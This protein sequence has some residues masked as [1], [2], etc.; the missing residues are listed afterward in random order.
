MKFAAKPGRHA[1][2]I[3]C[4]AVALLGSTFEVY[5]NEYQDRFRRASVETAI[6]RAQLGE[7]RSVQDSAETTGGTST[8]VR[9]IV[10]QVREHLLLLAKL[11]SGSNRVRELET[12][13]NS[14]LA[15]FEQVQQ[16]STL[17]RSMAELTATQ[18]EAADRFK[19]VRQALAAL[20]DVYAQ[21]G[22]RATTAN[23]VG[24]VL[25]L[26]LVVLAVW[27]LAH[28]LALAETTG[29]ANEYQALHDPL[30]GLPNRAYLSQHLSQVLSD[31]PAAVMLVDLDGFKAVNDLLGHEAGD[32]LLVEMGGR[33]RAAVPAHQFIARLGG[34]EFVVVLSGAVT[35]A[36][37]TDLADRMVAAANQS[38]RLAGREVFISA[39]I[40][41]TRAG[42]AQGG[43]LQALR[44][45][46]AAMYEAKRRGK[47]QWCD[48][49]L[50]MDLS[51]GEQLGL[52]HELRRAIEDGGLHLAYQ[53]I[54]D[55][56][57]TRLI[58]FEALVRW[59]HPERGLLLPGAFLPIAAETGLIVPLDR[60]VLAAACRQRA[61]W[62]T[63]FPGLPLFMS[64][65]LA[66]QNFWQADL[67]TYVEQ[68][69]AETG[70]APGD[71]QVELTE[72]TA[73][74]DIHGA[75]A[76]LSAQGIRVAIDDFGVGYSTWEYLLR[77]P[78][79]VLKLDR[80]LVMSV[81]TNARHQ[82]A[83][84]AITGFGVELGIRVIA[85]GIE[86][87]RQIETLRAIGVHWGQGFY[88]GRP[89]T[90]AECTALL[91]SAGLPIAHNDKDR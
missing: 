52:G 57:A 17:G 41:V 20:N 23:N 83:L 64:V 72:H 16:A 29:K 71:L 44:A 82:A 51:H 77:F 61:A 22:S 54:W 58:G 4:V 45:A 5:L 13:I 34:D 85:E 78:V 65:N 68:V 38:V 88:L 28:Q 9:Q 42:D 81:A 56:Q 80:S 14:Y 8:D 15:Q 39:S 53:P 73:V 74:E 2:L 46:D 11:D 30:T 67:P 55:L 49:L 24:S 60:W 63:Q 37:I 87:E 62:Q 40:G 76:A 70:I 90:L 12:G 36:Q 91:I 33:L 6:V 79:S 18:V 19:V 48:Y 27:Y 47:N 69:V 25:S 10:A 3:G 89:M 43:V 59:S 50:T 31:G 66:P 1:L 84:S 75:C 26:A 86:D 7:I 21:E 32:T 35:Q